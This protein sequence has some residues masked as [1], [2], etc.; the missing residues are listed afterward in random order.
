MKNIWLSQHKK[1][2][3]VHYGNLLSFSGH[4]ELQKIIG[5]SGI[6]F[7]YHNKRCSANEWIGLTLRSSSSQS[8]LEIAHELAPFLK[9]QSSISAEN[10]KIAAVLPNNVEIDADIVSIYSNLHMRDAFS[11]NRYRLINPKGQYCCLLYGLVSLVFY[12][13]KIELT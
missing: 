3:V 7:R 1:P 6:D 4:P 5:A 8:S 11:L 10:K 9:H 13:D 2:A 12:A